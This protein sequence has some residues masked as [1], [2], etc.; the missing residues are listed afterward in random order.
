MK[1]LEERH[2]DDEDHKDYEIEEGT[3][4]NAI[5]SRSGVWIYTAS[6]TTSNASSHLKSKEISLKHR[7]R[8]RCLK[9][10]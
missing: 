7:G 5:H 9:K 6:R 3:A 8:S 4:T 10:I 1:T 2:S